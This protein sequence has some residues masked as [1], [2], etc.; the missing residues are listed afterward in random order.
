[1][2]KKLLS[3]ASAEIELIDI[4][5]FICNLQRWDEEI[6]AFSIKKSQK[7]TVEVTGEFYEGLCKVNGYCGLS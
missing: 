3:E 7:N 6:D 5:L 2:D 4:H 1:M